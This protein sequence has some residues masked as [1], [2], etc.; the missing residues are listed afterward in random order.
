MAAPEPTLG[1]ERNQLRWLL[2]GFVGGSVAIWLTF[3]AVTTLIRLIP[4]PMVD[5]L[6]PRPGANIRPYTL[7][8]LSLLSTLLS[9]ALGGLIHWRAV[10]R[11]GE[12]ASWW[13]VQWAIGFFACVLVVGFVNFLVGDPVGRLG[14]VRA[15][16]VMTLIGGI[17]GLVLA[18]SPKVTVR[19]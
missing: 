19:R 7:I 18:G 5:T 16:I 3:G 17:I 14:N 1:P 9:G 13:M 4:P 2:P 8:V 11:H 12:K 10:G 6:V 15:S